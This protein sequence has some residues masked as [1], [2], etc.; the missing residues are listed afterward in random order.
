MHR[1]WA[2]IDTAAVR[3]NL[4]AIRARAGAARVM[5]VLKANAYGH[6]AVEMAR[7]L[8]N[9][10][11]DHL[12]VGDSG[13]ALELRDA[14]IAA[15]ILIVGG[16]IPGEMPAVVARD[17]EVNLHT[18]QMAHDLNAEAERQGRNVRVHLKI[19]TGMGR[20]GMQPFEAVPFLHQMKGLRSLE[21]VGLCTH[22]SSPYEENPAF[23][24]RQLE[25][26]NLAVE[27]AQRLGYGELMLHASSS[28]AV[29]Q[30][31]D[32]RF[33]MVRTGIALWGLLPGGDRGWEAA[34]KPALELKSRVL[35]LKDVPEG[36]PV[37]YNRTYYTPAPTRIATLPVGYND[38][39]R[40]S[41][42]NRASVVVHGR[43]CP[44]VGRVSMDYTTIDVGH[45]PQVQ[46][47]DEVTLIGPGVELYEVAQWAEAIPYE[48]LCGLGRRVARVY[49]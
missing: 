5:A 12:G 16:I 41:L 10:G 19:D 24:L 11:I 6:G 32:A 28:L 35:F 39:Y 31:P 44:V 30:H 37:G 40:T 13:E 43:R 45:A 8:V 36:T 33:N 47:G 15:P 27:L 7:L 3:H 25:H 46:V 26:F 18:V 14:G 29:W 23:T 22:F 49:R 17:I 38:G 34:L 1:V 20:L 2:E 48:I 21:L 42:S 4:A 9:E